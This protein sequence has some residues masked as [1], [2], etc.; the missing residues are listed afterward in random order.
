[1]H[2]GHPHDGACGIVAAKGVDLRAASRGCL[3]ATTD[4]NDDRFADSPLSKILVFLT[5]VSSR[6][7]FAFANAG[8]ILVGFPIGPLIGFAVSATVWIV[9][10]AGWVFSP[11]SPQLPAEHG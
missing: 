5:I 7:F 6:D 11:Q 4:S 1:M 2:S 10:V 8:M 9:F 3:D